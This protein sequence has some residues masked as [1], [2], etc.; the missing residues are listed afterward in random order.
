[1]HPITNHL[2]QSRCFFFP[3]FSVVLFLFFSSLLSTL[4]VVWKETC[5]E[6]PLRTEVFLIKQYRTS[7][8]KQTKSWQTEH[9]TDQVT[10]NRPSHH[11]LN[12]SL[13]T[14]YVIANRPNHY[15]VNK[16]LQTDQVMTNW[17]RNRPSHHKLNMS[18]QTDQAIT[19]WT[20]HSK[21]TMSLQTE[22]I[23]RI[24]SLFT[25]KQSGPIQSLHVRW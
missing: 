15:K 7:H 17:T 16:S 14:E 8:Y 18:L 5:L 3:S 25:L 21:K 24:Q 6:E 12:K 13:Q 19:K 4:S 22:Q 11:K 20:S 9:E 23:I 1:M 10:T 2:F